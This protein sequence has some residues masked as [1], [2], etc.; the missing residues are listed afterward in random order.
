[1]VKSRHSHIIGK[2]RSYSDRIVDTRE[3]LPRFLIICEGEKTEPRYFEAFR[4]PTLSVK[5]IRVIGLGDNTISLVN[6]AKEIKEQNNYDYVWCVFDRDSFPS[7]DFNSAI[8]SA[9]NNS[10]YVAYSNEAFEL[11][12]LLHFHFYDTAMSRIS[13]KKQLTKLLNHQYEKNSPTMYQELKD[14]QLIAI[15]N[16]PE[17]DNP[18]TTVHLLVQCLNALVEFRQKGSLSDEM[19][20]L[21]EDLSNYHSE[22]KKRSGIKNL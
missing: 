17:K 13:Y 5:D 9:Y 11:W 4:I 19:R 1:M 2:S 15:Q 16:G 22:A 20:Y 10:M 7:G 12:Y 14:K 6:K 21:K 3:S 8:I 18:S